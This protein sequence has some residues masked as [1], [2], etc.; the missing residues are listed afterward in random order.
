MSQELYENYSELI[1][2]RNSIKVPPG[3]ETIVQEML[4]AVKVYEKMEIETK[5]YINTTFTKIKITL[6]L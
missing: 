3:W 5:D 1:E 4:E 2:H 6:K